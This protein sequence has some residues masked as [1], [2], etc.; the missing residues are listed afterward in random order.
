MDPI[1]LALVMGGTNAVLG[2]LKAK[3]AQQRDYA[4]MLGNAE[5]M[6]YSPWTNIQTKMQ[7]PSAPSTGLSELGGALSGGLEGY[8]QGQNIKET[9]AANEANRKSQGIIDAKN[10]AELE[11]LQGKIKPVSYNDQ[12]PIWDNVQRSPQLYG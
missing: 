3:D 6:R 10:Q 8:A 2:G 12:F 9:K 4:T 7:G 1:T 5:A 11:V